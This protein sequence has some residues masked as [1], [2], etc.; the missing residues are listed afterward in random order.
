MKD[1]TTSTHHSGPW[2]HFWRS[3]F[4][5]PSTFEEYQPYVPALKISLIYLFVSLFWIIMSDTIVEAILPNSLNLLWVNIFKGSIFVIS[6][7]LF[8]FFR[9]IKDLRHISNLKSDKDSVHAAL[10]QTNII[11]SSY[12][13]SS[14]DIM[15]FSLDKEYRY[16]A[17]NSRHKYSVLREYGT[18]IY[19]GANAIEVLKDPD[20]ASQLK[21]DCDRAFEGEFF[22]SITTFGGNRP[23]SQSYWQ[24]YFSP[25]LNSERNPVGL[26]CFELNITP[27]KKAQEQN[28]FISY[29]DILTGLYN[30]RYFEEAIRKSDTAEELPISIILGDVNGLKMV[31]DAFGHHIGD[32]LLMKAA[33]IIERACL[34]K[35][36]AGRWGSDEF[37]I[38]L[39]Y[40]NAEEAVTLLDTIKAECSSTLVNSVP[41]DISF[42]LATKTFSEETIVSTMKSAEDRLNRNKIAES[43]SMRN[44]IIKTVMHALHEKSSREEA[45]SKRV[46]ELCRK[47]GT[48]MN[49]PDVEINLL[50]LAGFLHDIGKIAID[51]NILSKSGSL[52]EEEMASIRTHPEVG[53]RIL[54]SSYDVSEIS[55]AVLYHHERWDGSGYPE[56]LAGDQIPLHAQIIAVADSFDAMT[57]KRTYRDSMST[58]SAAKAIEEGA[59]SIYSPDVVNAFLKIVQTYEWGV[60]DFAL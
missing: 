58:E 11:F 41:V 34:N 19:I 60:D 59:G 57:G 52:T 28:L 12:L 4:T 14:P 56:G 50:N 33:D 30:R 49:L 45:H 27:F 55:E 35:G 46:G 32:K 7:T 8:I 20:K 17:F 9:I 29:H 24:R 5:T 31:N 16:L 43:K 15:V 10:D 54:R 6:T 1:K 22:S 53:C 44:N 13:E 26:T 48:A 21:A 47:I 38:L 18:E 39:P 51:D 3:F 40:H 25:I 2:R 37:I 36:I 42:G 23:D